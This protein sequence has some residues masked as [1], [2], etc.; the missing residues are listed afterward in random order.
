MGSLYMTVC[1]SVE[2]YLA[3]IHPF[4]YNMV[5]IHRVIVMI[6]TTFFMIVM[7]HIMV[8]PVVNMIIVMAEF[9]FSGFGENGFLFGIS[10]YQH[11]FLWSSLKHRSEF[12]LYKIQ[13][14]MIGLLQISWVKLKRRW[15]AGHKAEVSTSLNLFSD[16]PTSLVLINDQRNGLA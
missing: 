10:F 3:L 4:W 5:T 14:I 9:V 16:A 1:L 8:L 7:I 15:Q 11:S 13:N 2:R 12:L 6:N